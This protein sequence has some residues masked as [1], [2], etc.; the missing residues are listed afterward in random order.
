MA[1][2][3]PISRPRRAAAPTAAPSPSTWPCPCPSSPSGSIRPRRDTARTAR[4]CAKTSYPRTSSMSPPITRTNGGRSPTCRRI[5]RADVQHQFPRQYVRFARYI[6]RLSRS[7]EA[8]QIEA[9]QKSSQGNLGQGPSPPGAPS[10]ISSSSARGFPL[11]A[12]Y[13][14]RIFDLGQEGQLWPLLLV[15]DRAADG[16]W[17]T[18][19]G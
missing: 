7:L 10:A 14:T 1:T 16:R 6:R 11:R 9:L 13:K 3:R 18:S 8:A 2:A 5:F 12:V 19:G 4:A 17:R 15:G